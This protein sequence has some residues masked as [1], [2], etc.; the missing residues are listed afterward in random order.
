MKGASRVAQVAPK[1]TQLL[2]GGVAGT[3]VYVC[4]CNP[5]GHMGLIW[6]DRVGSN[7]MTWNGGLVTRPVARFI[8]VLTGRE[9]DFS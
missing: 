8:R 5:T 1:D 2:G 6:R 7:G 3:V 9:G 4:E